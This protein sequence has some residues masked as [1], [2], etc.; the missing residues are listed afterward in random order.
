M[1]RGSFFVFKR[2]EKVLRDRSKFPL[3]PSLR[4]FLFLFE[5]EVVGVAFNDGVL[6]LIVRNARDF[7]R[8][9]TYYLAAFFLLLILGKGLAP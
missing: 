3:G 9:Q 5:V 1:L 8:V 4:F 2:S 7:E 6:S